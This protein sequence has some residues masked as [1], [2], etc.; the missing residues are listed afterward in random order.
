[1]PPAGRG[2]PNAW[3]GAGGVGWRAAA[4]RD[5]PRAQGAL[6][7]VRPVEAAAGQAADPAADQTGF[8]S[9]VVQTRPAA[10][11]HAG[12]S[13]VGAVSSHRRGGEQL[14]SVA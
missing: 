14:R 13:R 12:H 8:A 5:A 9:G 1:M 7:A 10:A 6:S 2:E 3:R 4:R 11:G